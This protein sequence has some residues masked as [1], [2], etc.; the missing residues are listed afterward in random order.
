MKLEFKAEDFCVCT[1]AMFP[2]EDHD[3]D[4][5]AEY[6]AEQA[7]EKLQAML[8]SSD[9]LTFCMASNGS[10]Y[11]TRYY[12]THVGQLVNIQELK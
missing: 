1:K 3:S 4:C 10:I 6:S 11:F 9:T 5:E 7:N 8:S 12:P 2:S